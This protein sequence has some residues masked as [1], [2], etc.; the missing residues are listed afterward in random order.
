M[1]LNTCPDKLSELLPEEERTPDNRCPLMT[2]LFR[3]LAVMMQAKRL[4]EQRLGDWEARQKAIKTSGQWPMLTVMEFV[5][6]LND[7]S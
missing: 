6:V 2:I 7:F 3:D 1:L 4:M 5:P